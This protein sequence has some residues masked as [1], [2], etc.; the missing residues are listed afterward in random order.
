M[1]KSEWIKA[2]KNKENR[3]IEDGI[4]TIGTKL[5]DNKALQI[6]SDSISN[7][8]RAKFERRLNIPNKKQIFEI[9]YL[10][11]GYYEII[12][13]KSLKALEVSAGKQENGTPIIQNSVDSESTLQQW[14]IK[15]TGDGYFYIISRCNGLYIDIPA[16]NVE[17]NPTIQMYEGNGTNAQKF[18]FT[19]VEELKTDRIEN[20]TYYIASALNE[21]K[22]VSI[23]DGKYE[24]FANVHIWENQKKEYQKF[25]I[26]YNKESDIYI[27][28]A[29]HSNKSLDVSYGG[30]ENCT[31]VAQY[32]T[33]KGETE[34]WV[35][36]QTKDG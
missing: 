5:N 15:D 12:Q 20:G 2:E 18:S 16:G 30:Q 8:A 19:K 35:L 17:E 4:Y 6:E 22:V 28:T 27:I 23:S 3:T 9:K 24:N 11:N 26:E 7:N 34:Q 21:S 10:G 32:Q 1:G 14:T 13:Q 36:K 25:D 33:H 29:V 31:N